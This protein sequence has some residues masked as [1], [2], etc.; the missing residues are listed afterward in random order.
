MSQ[1]DA[2]R[3]AVIICLGI[4]PHNPDKTLQSLM[5]CSGVLDYF[6]AIHGNGYIMTINF[7]GTKLLQAKTPEQAAA[8]LRE[9]CEDWSTVLDRAVNRVKRDAPSSCK[10]VEIILI[11]TDEVPCR[12]RDCATL[13]GQFKASA[14]RINSI[15]VEPPADD[16]SGAPPAYTKPSG[17]TILSSPSRSSYYPE[18]VAQEPESY[19]DVF[20]DGWGM[21]RI[22]RETG[23]LTLLPN[24]E[25]K[26]AIHQLFSE[27]F[28]RWGE[29]YWKSATPAGPA[30]MM[31]G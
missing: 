10:F 5:V 25:G 27:M 17:W 20:E 18:D 21:V 12:I 6:R 14:L 29:S 26:L 4:H 1:Y 28:R 9:D 30:R 2:D 23:G 3:A 15:L 22:A 13:C 24:A 8:S 16:G 11:G 7:S 31:T 19:E